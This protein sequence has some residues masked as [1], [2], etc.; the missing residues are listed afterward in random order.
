MD[1]NGGGESFLRETG[2]FSKGANSSRESES[3]RQHGHGTV[4]ERGL[5]IYISKGSTV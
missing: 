5:N 2:G 1:L 3:E 4:A